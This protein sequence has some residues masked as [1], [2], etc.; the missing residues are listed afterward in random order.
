MSHHVPIKRKVYGQ[1][2][3]LDL[4]PRWTKGVYLGPVWDVG[5]GS[6]VLDETSKRITVT[7]HISIRPN[8]RNAESVAERPVQEFEPPV[9]RRLRAKAPVDEDGVQVRSLKKNASDK[10]RKTLEKEILAE[11][12]ALGFKMNVKRPQLREQEGTLD[13][14]G[15][16]TVGAYQHGG[17]HGVTNFT[18][19]HPD[20]TAKITQLFEMVLPEELFT[21]VTIVKNTKMPLHLQ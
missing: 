10:A 21:S 17:K 7:T 3:R 12:D 5:K 15:Y 13:E 20:L 11:I 16:T 8:L 9:R 4:I 14:E 18:K 1:G 6:A 2:G 19:E